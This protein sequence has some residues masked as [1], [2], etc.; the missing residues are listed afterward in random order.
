MEAHVYI[1]PR[2]IA[3]TDF[4]VECRADEI[5]ELAEPRRGD[6]YPV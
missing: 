1:A 5:L 4:S 3:E 2:R 6:S